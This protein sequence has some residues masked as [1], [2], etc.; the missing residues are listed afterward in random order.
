MFTRFPKQLPLFLA[1]I[2]GLAPIAFFWGGMFYEIKYGRPSSTSSIGFIIGPIYGLIVS[3]IGYLIGIV[4]RSIWSKFTSS[5]LSPLKVKAWSFL[6][7]A[8]SITIP[9]FLGVSTVSK[10][11][12]GTEPAILHDVGVFR[13]STDTVPV[14]QI[15][16]SAKIFEAYKSSDS[17]KWGNNETRILV[18][19]GGYLIKDILNGKSC[20]LPFSGLDYVTRV[21]GV[22]LR[23]ANE[24]HPVLALVIT[25]R[26]TG[27]RAVLAVV[28][29]DY[30]L[31]YAERIDRFWP[32]D[33]NPLAVFSGKKSNIDMG[34]VGPGRDEKRIFFVSKAA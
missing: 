12:K 10:Y 30:E 9:I 14:S 21:Y 15:K 29:K 23:S 16:P 20:A 34:I 24:A 4:A 7:V 27:R 25:G 13:Y 26:A 17:L 6:I 5:E 32:L 19:D 8:L 33:M 11:I 1:L 3:G 31:L 18:S 28:S 22:P 2:A